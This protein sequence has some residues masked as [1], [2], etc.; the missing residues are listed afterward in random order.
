MFSSLDSLEREIPIVLVQ[1]DAPPEDKQ[2][3]KKDKSG[4]SISAK[5]P[6]LIPIGPIDSMCPI[7]VGGYS[8]VRRQLPLLPA[9]A[10]S[11]H[12][13][14]GV[15]AYDGAVVDPKTKFFAGPYVAISRA[16]SLDAVFLTEA[17]TEENFIVDSDYRKV[18]E[19][20]YKQ[21]RNLFKN[22][23][24]AALPA[25]H[26][27]NKKRERGGAG[28][29]RLRRQQEEPAA[30]RGYIVPIIVDILLIIVFIFILIVISSIPHRG[31]H[32][33]RLK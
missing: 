25:A 29:R 5:I 26:I 15:T 18:V 14:Q 2:E 20:E 6:N 27:N 23:I 7:T 28:G 31:L 24:L 12:S 30:R 3:G 19:S 10:R 16:R 17:V 1:F 11:I 13:I 9:F 21:L 32:P 33:R 8:Y 4:I 22:P